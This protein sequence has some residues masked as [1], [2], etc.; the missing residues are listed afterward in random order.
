MSLKGL[1]SKNSRKRQART[2]LKGDP[3]ERPNFCWSLIS[4]YLKKKK[5]TSG[6]Y[7]N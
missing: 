7:I 5:K 2:Q 6:W 3:M 1:D 4:L